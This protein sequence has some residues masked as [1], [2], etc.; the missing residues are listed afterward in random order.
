MLGSTPKSLP[1]DELLPPSSLLSL[2]DVQQQG[3]DWIVRADVLRIWG[4]EPS[5]P[6][7]NGWRG[8]HAMVW[9][10]LVVGSA[11]DGGKSAVHF[12]DIPVR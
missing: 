9:G 1:G 10:S 6:D 8:D 4:W 5:G 7:G 2:T 3:P 11:H 12:G